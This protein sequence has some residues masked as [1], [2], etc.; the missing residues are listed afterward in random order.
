MEAPM[1][2]DS[3]GC[4]HEE[5]CGPIWRI[6]HPICVL[7]PE[8]WRALRSLTRF[9]VIDSRSSQEQLSILRD[10][11][12]LSL[13]R[14][15]T[16]KSDSKDNGMPFERERPQ[17]GV[18]NLGATPTTCSKPPEPPLQHFGVH[19]EVSSIS[20]PHACLA[21]IVARIWPVQAWWRVELGVP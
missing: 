15:C 19:N 14:N 20:V 5:E 13:S 16:C 17:H 3:H 2:R 9:K 1:Q 8:S 10:H 18:S 21:K 7:L 4:S 12:S 6:A 11:F